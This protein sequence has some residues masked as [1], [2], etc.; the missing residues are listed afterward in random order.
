MSINGDDL[1]KNVDFNKMTEQLKLN[2]SVDAI[3]DMKK[4]LKVIRDIVNFIE[5][6]E[7][8]VMEKNNLQLFESLVV[9]K[10]YNDV[11]NMKIINL[12]LDKEKRYENLNILIDMMTKLDEIKNGKRDLHKEHEQFVENMNEKYVYTKFGGKEKFTEFVNSKKDE[13]EAKKNKKK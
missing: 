3:P 10:Y 11:E 7:M 9:N 6:P 12:L 2:M 5:S 4:R 13:V 1:M 8:K